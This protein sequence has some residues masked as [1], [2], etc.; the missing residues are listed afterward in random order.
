MPL[1]Y[2]PN[3]PKQAVSVLVNGDLLEKAALI[4]LNLSAV[5]ESAIAEAVDRFHEAEQ[6]LGEN[7]DV[8]LDES[9][10]QIDPNVLGAAIGVFGNAT[11]A[12]KWLITPARALGNKRPV[13]A[14][15]E[16]VMDL[17]ARIENGFGA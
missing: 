2:D 4:D 6:G 3:A 13:E 8:I 9:V 12:K 10:G 1:G 5:L 11:L 14:D 16:Q 15:I 7:R 17:I